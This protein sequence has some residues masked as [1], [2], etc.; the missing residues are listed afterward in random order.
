MCKK[1]KVL[2]WPVINYIVDMERGH[3]AAVNL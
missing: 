1:I 2:G 3:A